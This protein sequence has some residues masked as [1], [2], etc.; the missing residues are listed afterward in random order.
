MGTAIF[1]RS[2]FSIGMDR[3]LT[4]LFYLIFRYDAY[5][6]LSKKMAEATHT[7]SKSL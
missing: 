6:L 7:V 4:F 3:V 2:L 5:G 1:I